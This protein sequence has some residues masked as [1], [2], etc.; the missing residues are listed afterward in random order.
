[1][2]LER[3]R[4]GDEQRA[5]NLELFFDL[6]FVFAITQVSHLL[7][8]DLS[9][10][11][12]ERAL[13][14]LLV[15]WWAWNYTAWVTNELDPE[16]GAVRLLLLAVMLGSLLLAV[17]IPDA[18]GERAVLFAG[19]YVAIQVGRHT[20]LTFAAANR[21]T[22]ERERAGRILIWFAAAGVL[23]I[24]GALAGTGARGALDGGAARRLLRADRPLLGARQAPPAPFDVGGRD[25]ALRR[26]IPALRDHRARRVDRDHGRHHRR[27]RAE[28]RSPY[29]VRARVRRKRRTLV[30]LFRLRRTDRG[31]AARAGR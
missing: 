20:F 13:L 26:A 30:A 2:R 8:D 28:H 31:A 15:V 23:W 7:L 18:F 22:I 5:T 21:G 4:A 6:V 9:W 25:V 27:S 16:S 10:R 1:M 12:A 3:R 17:A 24:A 19:S 29:D 14:A 11:G